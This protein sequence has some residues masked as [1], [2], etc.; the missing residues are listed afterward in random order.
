MEVE[1]PSRLWSALSLKAKVWAAVAAIVVIVPLLRLSS[2]DYAIRRHQAYVDEVALGLTEELP[3]RPVLD[4]P[5]YYINKEGDRRRQA[6]FEDR[7]NELYISPSLL[8]RIP[9]VDGRA[10]LEEEWTTS[11]FR[12]TAEE[13]GR[14][15]SHLSAA[16]E[17]VIDG[18]E[19]ALIVEDDAHFALAVRWPFK[20]S[21]LIASLPP[22]WTSLQ[23]FHGADGRLAPEVDEGVSATIVP[24]RTNM[25]GS[26]AY[27]LHRRRGAEVLLRL[28]G[29]GREL[30]RAALGTRDGKAD[31]VMFEFPGASAYALW[32]RYIFPDVTVSGHGKGTAAWYARL[33][34]SILDQGLA[35]WPKSERPGELSK[36]D[37]DEQGDDDQ[38]AL[39]V[40]DEFLA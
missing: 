16:K 39:V 10:H 26:L 9:A 22:T 13:L 32:P 8:V 24:R 36:F 28:T 12:L 4:L 38:R 21:D 31:T 14:T 27:V 35:L 2:F 3:A 23:L 5:V 15:L 40:L 25:R 29:Q 30:H 1:S 37:Y 7:I 19:A 17:L 6:A 20:L 33:A 18:H 34:H 11:G